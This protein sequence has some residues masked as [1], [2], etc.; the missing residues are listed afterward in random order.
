MFHILWVYSREKN[1]QK[2]VPSLLLWGETDNNKDHLVGSIM[3]FNMISPKEKIFQKNGKRTISFLLLEKPNPSFRLGHFHPH[4]T[5]FLSVFLT[6][7][8]TPDLTL[9]LPLPLPL[10]LSQKA[11]SEL[12]FQDFM[13]AQLGQKMFPSQGLWLAFIRHTHKGSKG[14]VPSGLSGGSQL[15]LWQPQWICVQAPAALSMG[16]AWVLHAMDGGA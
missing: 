16:D 6:L 15:T 8:P 4:P 9:P 3:L 12:V 14:T 7:T 13:C 10:N 5:G 2:S 1:R 11:L